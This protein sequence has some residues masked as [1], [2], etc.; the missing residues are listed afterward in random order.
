MPVTFNVKHNP[1]TN[2]MIVQRY[3]VSKTIM[4]VNN[5]G[6]SGIILSNI[7]NLASGNLYFDN[8]KKR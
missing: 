7:E 5:K 4:E 2:S 6:N 1:G 8:L 3:A